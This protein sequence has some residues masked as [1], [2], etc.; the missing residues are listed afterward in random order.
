MVVMFQR[1]GL[2][3]REAQDMA[4]HIASDRDLWLRTMVEKELGLSSE[5]TA[6][7]IKDAMVMGLAFIVAAMVPIFPFFFLEGYTAIGT[8]SGAALLGLFCL[9]RGQG[10]D[11][12][13]VA[14]A[15]RLGDTVGGRCGRGHRLRPRRKHTVGLRHLKETYRNWGD[16]IFVS[17]AVAGADHSA[18]VDYQVVAVDGAP[19]EEGGQTLADS[20]G[21]AL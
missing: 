17:V 19:F 12:A 1:E 2:T 20:I 21:V 8:S 14:P 10:P 7:P 6:N 15:P 13:Q 16:L 11:S 3:M 5:V 9:G 4:E 18:S